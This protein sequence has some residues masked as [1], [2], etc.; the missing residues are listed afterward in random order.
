M[1]AKPSKPA[2]LKPLEVTKARSGAVRRSSSRSSSSSSS[3]IDRISAPASPLPRQARRDSPMVDQ[4]VQLA[5]HNGIKVVPKID[6]DGATG[7]QD[8]EVALGCMPDH[9][10]IPL[11]PKWRYDIRRKLVQILENEMNTLEWIQSFRTPFLDDYFL[12]S[13]LLGTHTFFMIG[14]PIPCWFGR[15]DIGREM[16]LVLACGGYV[17]SVLKDL[18]CV[19]RPYSPPLVRLSVGTHALEYGFPSTHSCTTI[20]MAFF[21]GTALS[22]TYPE[23]DASMLAAHCALGFV[24]MS[25]IVGR[26][27]AGMHSMMDCAVGFVTGCLV[28]LVWWLLEDLYHLYTLSGGLLVTLTS[29]PLTLFLVFVHPTPAEDCPCFEDA[30]AFVSATLGTVLGRNWYQRP[31]K[32]ITFGATLDSPFAS[33]IWTAAIALKLILGIASIFIWRIAAKAACHAVL[34]KLFRFFRMF[35]LPRRFYLQATEY[36]GYDRSEGLYPVPSILDLPSLPDLKSPGVE[37]RADPFA[38]STSAVNRLK[39]PDQPRTELRSR[40]NN[41]MDAPETPSSDSDDSF[42]TDML[43]KERLKLATLHRDEDVVREFASDAQKQSQQKKIGRRRGY[44]LTSQ[45]G[46]AIRRDADVLTRVICYLG[47]GWITTIGIPWAFE[48]MGLS[49]QI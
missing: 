27:Y 24:T 33:T 7:V 10:Y 46:E 31:V 45:D 4:T 36:D 3:P 35:L 34:P 16:L 25:V 9:E 18:F 30:V 32:H 13:S 15:A 14:L 43:S 42:T 38:A 47:V 26:M 19:P 22:R 20:S 40:S 48:K 41:A 8:H 6:P 28:W 5:T 21:L 37:R 49:I 29:V 39:R 1:A 17:T 12:K 44:S 11:M 23:A 2:Q